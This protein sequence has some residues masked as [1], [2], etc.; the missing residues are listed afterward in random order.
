MSYLCADCH[1]DTTPSTGGWEYYMVHNAVWSLAGMKDG[2]YA[3]AALRPGSA[4]SW[5]RATSQMYTAATPSFPGT[6]PGSRAA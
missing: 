4:E 2:F 3:S 1:S 6:V 5:S